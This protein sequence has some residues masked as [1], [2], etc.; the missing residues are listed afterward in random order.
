M[1][2]ITLFCRLANSSVCVEKMYRITIKLLVPVLL[3]SVI[4][5]GSAAVY[6]DTGVAASKVKAKKSKK[7]H[8]KKAAVEANATA[9]EVKDA[10]V[11]EY[12]C[13]FG[14]KLTILQHVGDDQHVDLRWQKQLHQLTRVDT[15][16]GANRFEN[17]TAG[18]VWI[19]IPAKGMLLDSKK[20]QPLANECKSAAQLSLLQK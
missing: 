17:Q 10:N 5:L 3:L 13:E 15:T 11:V 14:K 4:S 19:G 20:G 8:V 18:L 16:T 7:H 12:S 1:R 6:A 9:P 2:T